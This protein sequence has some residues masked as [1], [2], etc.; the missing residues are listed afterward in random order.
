MITRITIIVIV[1]MVFAVSLFT[2]DSLK[3]CPISEARIA[4]VNKNI[5]MGLR[6]GNKGVIEAS[7]ILIA[8]IKMFF[9]LTNIAEIRTVIDSLAITSSSDTLRYKAYLTSNI[10][11]D[12]EWFSTEKSMNT[13]E[14]DQF[15]K[16]AAQRLQ[17]KMLGMNSF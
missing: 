16:T 2:Q 1:T 8:K 12:P 10:C 4:S 6:S 13:L 7:L 17:N 3:K 11:T 9:P 5:L 15:Y 14:L